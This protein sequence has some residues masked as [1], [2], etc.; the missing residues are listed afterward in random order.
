MINKYLQ[1]FER[2]F[3]GIGLSSDT[4]S[5]LA[6]G[7]GVITLLVVSFLL[8]LIVKVILKKGVGKL[9]RKTKF[10]YDDYFLGRKLERRLAFFIPV[11]MIQGMIYAVAPD[12]DMLCGF[13]YTLARIGEITTWTGVLISIT[14][15]LSDIY[16]SFDVSKNKP[17]KGFM[18]V[19]KI[20]VI[21]ICI[22]L[23][24]GVLIN[25]DMRDI[26]IGLGTLSAVMMLVFKDPI[27][28]FVGGIQLTS[29]DMVRIGDW[30]V[31]GNAA[32]GTVVDVGLTTVKVQ[33]WDNTISTIPT[34]SLITDP[35]INWRGMSESGGRR[36]ARQIYIDAD[37][38]KFCA[39]EMLERFK[40][41][42]LVSKYITDKENEIAEYNNAH[43]VD[44]STLVNGRRQTNLG[45]FRAYLIEYL[46]H[47]D[48]LNF[49]MTLLVRQKDPTEFGV[50]L[51]IYC[52]SAKTDWPSYEAIQ[53]DIFDH[54][55]AV[56][57]QFD[58]KVYQKPSSNTFEYVKTLD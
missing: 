28:G 43:N 26:F 48:D 3:S 34:Y 45:I 15:S 19:A 52:F 30:I 32:D 54:I 22:L 1:I 42:Q 17:M 55:Y 39:P 7:L 35:F 20:F 29:N 37:S 56:I 9:I 58:L 27:L 14:D 11:Y 13:I 25:K 23:I 44:T 18:Q 6:Q 16:N 46:K 57:S 21:M 51:Q 53:S 12:L 8:F 38:V 4:A 2:L 40:K 24:I 49:K 10:K 5:G 33:N 31:K 47:R 50:P 41:F 36:I